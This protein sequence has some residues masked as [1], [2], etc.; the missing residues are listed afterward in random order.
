ML[1]LYM[2]GILD[3]VCSAAFYGFSF[4]ILLLQQWGFYLQHSVLSLH[5]TS[6]YRAGHVCHNIVLAWYKI[7]TPIPPKQ[8]KWVEFRHTF[9]IRESGH[10]YSNML[11][12]FNKTLMNTYCFSQYVLFFCVICLLAFCTQPS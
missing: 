9:W 6:V 1:F 4:F 8:W 11:E 3:A 7:K 2:L 5:V 10:I 12:T